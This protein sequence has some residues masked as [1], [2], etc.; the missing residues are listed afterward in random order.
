MSSKEAKETPFIL[1]NFAASGIQLSKKS[2]WFRNYFNEIVKGYV[3][4]GLSWERNFYS[5]FISVKIISPPKPLDIKIIRKNGNIYL[6]SEDKRNEDIFINVMVSKRSRGWSYNDIPN[7]NY[8]NRFS[9][10]YKKKYLFLI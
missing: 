8:L 6:F 3:D 7:K 10:S 2:K 4:F 5:S 1:D 9:E